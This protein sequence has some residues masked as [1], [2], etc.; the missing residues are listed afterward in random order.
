MA[1]SELTAATRE[2]LIS[3]GHQP[4]MCTAKL[5]ESKDPSVDL[6]VADTAAV[7]RF[8]P[9][10]TPMPLVV[11]DSEARVEAAR[12]AYRKGA[13]E[14]IVLP[15]ERDALVKLVSRAT[16]AS[17]P[18]RQRRKTPTVEELATL[19]ERLTM[20][21]VHDLKNPLS[22]V[23][24][25]LG[26]LAES[27][28]LPFE[29]RQEILHEAI[30]ATDR[31]LMMIVDLLDIARAEEGRLALA[32]TEMNLTAMIGAVARPLRHIAARR[33]VTLVSQVEG[34]L[35]AQ[36]DGPLFQRVLENIINNSLRYVPDG[37]R[38]RI[39]AEKRISDGTTSTYV[40]I[41]NNGPKIPDSLVSRLF[42]KYG[43]V[44]NGAHNHRA[45]N[46][47]L[48]LY[49][50]RLVVEAHGGTLTVRNLPEGVRFEITL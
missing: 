50:C 10:V 43:A 27:D 8:P 4:I 41:E 42:E 11:V 35:P 30:G 5:I 9:G 12:D 45:G 49:F 15:A 26:L 6:V 7:D 32:K 47:G 25:D 44:E 28:D 37:G 46:R 2:L 22:I 48:G 18:A 23:R 19:K 29:E 16:E 31:L 38:V 24:A 13:L 34:T 20:L 33:K 14:Y 39:G 36:L 21:L 3:A 40:F 17:D 1:S